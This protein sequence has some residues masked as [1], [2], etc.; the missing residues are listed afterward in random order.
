MCKFLSLSAVFQWLVFSS[1]LSLMLLELGFLGI[2][3][4]GVGMGASG[5]GTQHMMYFT[6]YPKSLQGTLC[7]KEKDSF[8]SF[9]KINFLQVWFIPGKKT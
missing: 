9:C 6:S 2:K 7:A 5:R 3:M 1:K 4:L 8:F